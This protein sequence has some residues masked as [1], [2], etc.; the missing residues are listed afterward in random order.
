MKHL[1]NTKIDYH[2]MPVGANRIN[3]AIRYIANVV[4]TWLWFHI[5]WPWVKYNGFVRI[6]KGTSFAAG[7]KIRLGHNVQFGPHC[8]VATDLVVGNNVL[9]AARVCF[10]GKYDHQFST[11][12]KT[13]WESERG[14]SNP[15][16]IED[17]VWLGHNV[18]VVGPVRIGMGAVV[19]AGAVVTKDIPACEIW[20]G[21]PARKI[22]DRFSSDEETQRHLTFLRDKNISKG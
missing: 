18:T 3:Y 1:K 9:F 19:A 21:V 2:N 7:M 22:R 6:M 8:N 13:I 11:P 10:V 12:C 5:K 17:D 4:R 20:G 15:T 14:K 16:I